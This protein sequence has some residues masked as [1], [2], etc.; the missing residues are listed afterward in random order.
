VK[1]H[2]ALTA[3]PDRVMSKV[4]VAETGCWEWTAAKVAGY[5]RV[6]WNGRS[7]LA[8]R[9]IYELTVGPVPAGLELDHL[10][11]NRACCNPD[12]LEPVTH[13]ENVRRA[14]GFAAAIAAQLAK[15]HCPHGHELTPENTYVPPLSSRPQRQCRTCRREGK[16]RRRAQG[17]AN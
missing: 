13:A 8:Y 17:K 6:R 1:V 9:V 14:G 2:E 7:A 10:C 16:R 5:G 11:R 4:A 12:H 15:T 3:V